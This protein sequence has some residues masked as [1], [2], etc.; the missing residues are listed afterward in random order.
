MVGKLANPGAEIFDEVFVDLE[1]EK[2]LS[3]FRK[4]G[5]WESQLVRSNCKLCWIFYKISP[6]M[7]SRFNGGAMVLD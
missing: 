4:S 3:L 6:W 1:K 7:L 2:D 5:P